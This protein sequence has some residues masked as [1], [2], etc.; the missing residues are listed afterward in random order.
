MTPQTRARLTIGAALVLLVAGIITL[1]VLVT[2]PSSTPSASAAPSHTLVTPSTTSS[3]DEATSSTSP[4]ASSGPQVD[5]Q[6]TA[7]AFIAAIAS[8]TDPAARQQAL[9]PL[10]APELLASITSSDQEALTRA[11]DGAQPGTAKD[12][13]IPL[14]RDGKQVAILATQ[15]APRDDEESGALTGDPV[16]VTGIDLT[17]A[18][19]DVALPLGT[20]ATTEIAKVAQPAMTA[21][22]AQPGGLTDA[23]RA[24]Q[25]T[26]AFTHPE[27]ALTI[28][29]VGTEEQRVITGNVQDP[30]LGVDEQGQLTLTAVMAW[31]VDGTTD[32]QW[33]S[34]TITLERGPRGTWVPRDA[35]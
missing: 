3:S 25:I 18:P 22:I 8:T 20:D 1:A 35:S 4:S 16:V 30:Q 32:T 29:R 21:L 15:T 6:A 26:D 23:D 14:M 31:R 28:P 34:H 9:A 10:T 2:R 19:K 7:S 24:K 12:G 5:P 33:A 17:D 11:L 13:T 27:T